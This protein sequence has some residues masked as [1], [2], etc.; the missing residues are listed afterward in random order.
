LIGVSILLFTLAASSADQE[1]PVLSAST[2]KSLNDFGSCFARSQERRA[3][4][5]AFVANDHGGV[6]TDF[7]AADTVAPYRLQV[8]ES[9]GSS[10]VRLFVRQA[11]ANATLIDAV[12]RCR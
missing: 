7:G 4:P 12:N 2:A 6:F 10:R 11:S 1:T 8:S 9:N 5:W 3:R